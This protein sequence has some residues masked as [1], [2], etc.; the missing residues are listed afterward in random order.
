M[1]RNKLHIGVWK[2]RKG[3]AR[4][5]NKNRKAAQVF[6]QRQVALAAQGAK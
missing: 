6:R 1:Q 2:S 3:K 4:A 5:K